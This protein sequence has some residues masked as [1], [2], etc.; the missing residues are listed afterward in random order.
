MKYKSGKTPLLEEKTLSKKFNTTI[1][2]K[3]E[4]KNPFGTLKDRRSELIVT[5]AMDE[6]VDK[7]SLITSGNAGY[8]L[9]RFSKG[10][11]IKVVNVV[12]RKLKK[13]I[14]NKLGKDGKVV[15]VDLSKKILKPEEVIS[16]ARENDEEVI[17]DVTN[18]FH[19]AY[20]K[21]IEEIK[22]VNPSIIF[23]P[24]GSGETFVGLYNGI[25]SSKLKTKLIG[26][27]VK[28]KQG[29]FADKL[30]TPWT[31]YK[32]KIKS[33]L[34]EDHK[35]IK[36]EEEE[37]KRAYKQ[38]ED[39]FNIEPSSAVVFGALSKIKFNKDDKIVI[40]NSGKGLV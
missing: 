13:S 25:K 19:K 17:W 14:K 11:K 21:I 15:E 23:V 22:K 38:Y 37:I 5:E 1:F 6:K 26:V 4:S 35:I 24:V 28:R 10:N 39:K 36:L 40:I 33:I 20:R 29:S 9:E 30:Y 8:S 16:L 32:A 7:L 18:G 34:K 31:P 27:G 3:D 2:I 12:D